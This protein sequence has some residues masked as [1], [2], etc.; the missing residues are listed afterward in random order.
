[1]ASPENEL[2]EARAR[3]LAR[4]PAAPAGD[5]IEV[6]TFMLA[7]ETYAI[8]SR[9]VLEVFRLTD[10]TRLPGAEAPIFGIAAW[11]G[12]LLTILDLRPVLGL[13]A[14]ALDDLGRVLVLGKDEAAFG[15]LADAVQ[16]LIAVPRSTV[17]EPAD[18]VALRREYLQ[19]VTGEAVIVL[20]AEKLLALHA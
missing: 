7:G 5:S 11:R 14:A 4:P 2:L 16:D 19:G 20:A 13:S 9:Y 12:E 3:A 18:G 15:V 1:M 17:R 8:E 10:L 6:V